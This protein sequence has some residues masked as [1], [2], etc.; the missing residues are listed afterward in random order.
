MTKGP[1]KREFI[2]RVVDE[3]LPA[4]CNDPKRRYSP[5]DAPLAG[6][7]ITEEDARDFLRALHEGVIDFAERQYLKLGQGER[8]SET[9]FTEGQE[10]FNPRRV[11]VWLETVITVAAAARLHLDHH[12]PLDLLT[13][14][15]NDSAFDLTAIRAPGLANE[16]IAVE[17]K[18]STR[19][20][21]QMVVN[22]TK[23]CSGDHDSSCLTGARKNA[24]RKW[25]ALQARRPA[26]FWAVG[27]WPDSR[28][29]KVL[30]GD[31]GQIRSERTDE[32]KLHFAET[33]ADLRR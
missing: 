17:V 28:V 31:T 30:S 25:V 19:E 26:L 14:Q 9:L 33:A 8:S 7:I 18:K 16:C 29:F 10:E 21:D 27:P 12:W 13:I 24:H 5:D 23:C 1:A 32:S 22:L 6:R 15:S 2:R 20:V 3:W 11:R 4:Y